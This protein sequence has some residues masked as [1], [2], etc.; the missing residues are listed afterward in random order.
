M[1]KNIKSRTKRTSNFAKLDA[2]RNP[3]GIFINTSV[4]KEAGNCFMKNG[5]YTPERW[6]T[7][8]WVEFWEEELRRCREGYEVGGVKITGEHYGYLN[9]AP[10]QKVEMSNT[11]GKSRAAIKVTG[12]PDFWDGDYN[13][14]HA[15]NIAFK[16]CTKEEY[17][18]L[19]LSVKI[20]EEFM[21][22][23]YHM[24]VGKARRKGYSFKNG[25]KCANNYNTI[26]GSLSIVGAFDKKYLY[27]EGTMGM[28]SNYLNFLNEHTGFRKS[29]DY[30][31]RQE[32]RRAS[33][34]KVV[35]GVEIES[36]YMSDIMA[37][38]FKD[39]PDAARGKDAMLVLLEEA[40]KFPNLQACYEATKPGLSAGSFIT[41][42]IV[43]F[44]TG[45]DMQSGTVD[46]AHMFYN[47]E[48]FDL[49]AF[50]NIWDDNAES[51][52]CG[53]FHPMHWNKEGFYDEQGNSLQEECIK[54]ELEARQ[55][56]IDKGANSKILNARVQ[57]FPTKPAEAFLTVGN[58]IFPTK[59]LNDRLNIV[60]RENLHLKLG[61]PV[62][63]QRKDKNTVILKPD[64]D[65][66]LQPIYFQDSKV[67]DTTGCVVMYEAPIPNAPIGMYKIGYDPYR[68]DKGTSYA[69]II[70]F[71][72][73]HKNSAT[74]NSIVAEYVGRP[75]DPDDVNR[76]FE[77]LC[78]AYNT[79]G[80]FENEVT[81]VKSY[82]S[83]RNKLHLLAAQ[84]DRVISNAIKNSK[85]RRIYGCHMVDKLKDAA[86]KYTKSWLLE[87]RDYDEDGNLVSTID[88]INSPGLLQEL[89]KYNRKDNFDRVS[90]LFMCMIQVQEDELEREYE[91]NEVSDEEKV[92]IFTELLKNM[93]K[94]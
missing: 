22:G 90:A 59:E 33:Y 35:D 89:I 12:F 66:V 47:P 51:S 86:E 56:L 45:G 26:R 87:E 40:G 94:K 19:M 68:Q 36:G 15:C 29:R 49:M 61:Q 65:N 88:T 30:V 84:P 53:F 62:Y 11:N 52:S 92:N 77:M 75:D 39:N 3:D 50:E 25:W 48:V 37:I 17:E 13:Y 27:P 93:Y 85:V 60:K 67:I 69:S 72:G 54:D 57:E 58:N 38:T 76:I 1:A 14:F 24:I 5:Y 32:H 7:P 73:N 83:R 28:A 55:K 6:G 74:R 23:G 63:L 4:F 10:I 70:V 91:T 16:G 41:G 79:K 71:K 20:K 9:Y 2:V 34:K 31:D 42:Q 81:H 21:G 8:A 82:F 78:E 44:G 46:F 80:M 43:I 64:L 18:K